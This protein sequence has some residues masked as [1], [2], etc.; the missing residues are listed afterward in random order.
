VKRTR[1]VTFQ[2]TLFLTGAGATLN[3]LL[4]L[5]SLKLTFLIS[6]VSVELPLIQFAKVC[7]IFEMYQTCVF[8]DSHCGKN[9]D[10]VTRVTHYQ[11][12]TKL[13]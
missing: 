5:F 4:I 8:C 9:H 6:R 11:G 7:E 1:E 3:V 10:L 13:P 2:S 12:V